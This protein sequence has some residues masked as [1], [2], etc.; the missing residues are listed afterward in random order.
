[1]TSSGATEL[2]VGK[3]RVQLS[4]AAHAGAIRST[5]VSDLSDYGDIVISSIKS[6]QQLF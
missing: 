3:L 6:T 5:R 2:I 1:M 4:D